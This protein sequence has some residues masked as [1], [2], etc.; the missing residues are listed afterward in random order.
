MTTTSM[1]RHLLLLLLLFA[2]LAPTAARADDL[3]DILGTGSDDDDDDSTVK[4]EKDAVLSGN[5]DDTVGVTEGDVLTP[6]DQGDHKKRL[7]KTLQQ[8][9]FLKIGR[10]EASPKF[11]FVTNDPYINRLLLGASFTAHVTEIYGF[12]LDVAFSPDLG[13]ADWKPV[14]KQLILEN[15]VS[16]DFSRILWYSHLDFEFSPIYGKVAVLGRGI[17]NFDVYGTFGAGAVGTRDDLEALQA[18][19]DVKAQSTASQVHP[20]TN[21]GGGL[22]ILLNPTVAVRVEGKSL[23]YIETVSATTLEMK[24]TFA[25]YG[26]VSFFF[27]G[28]K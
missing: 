20:T 22:R 5:L 21:I 24:G 26:G 14:T 28:M 13:E 9:T 27:P 16:P 11:G 25:L 2:G 3:D 15:Q 10:Y 7:I 8:K 6:E 12:E 18:E 23:L 19:N 1:A 4:E 17:V